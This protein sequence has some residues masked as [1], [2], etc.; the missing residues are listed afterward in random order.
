MV[1]MGWW[2]DWIASE[3]FPNLNDSML[4]HPSTLQFSYSLLWKEWDGDASSPLLSLGHGSEHSLPSPEEHPGPQGT[5][6]WFYPLLLNL[7]HST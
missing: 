5:Q 3:V 1:G 7:L 6:S 2:F 4:I